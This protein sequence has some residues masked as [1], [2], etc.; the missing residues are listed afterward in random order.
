MATLAASAAPAAPGFSTSLSAPTVASK[1]IANSWIVRFDKDATGKQFRNTRD[2]SKKRGAK[3]RYQYSRVFQGFAATM[4]DAEVAKLRQNA[5]VLSV[6]PDYEVHASGTQS[7]APSWGL[8]RIDQRALPLSGGYTYS[9]TGSG[10]TAY[11][12]D[13][14]IRASHNDFGG[15]VKAGYDVFTGGTATTD[16]NGHGTHVAGTIGGTTYGVAKQVAL[17]PVRVLDCNGGGSTSGVIA[18][19]DWVTSHHQSAGGPAVANMSLGGSASQAL[20]T[21]VNSAITAGVSFAVAAG[22][23][24]GNAC[25]YS[26][27]RVPAAVTVGASTTSDT[28]ASFSNGGS[29]VDIFAPGQSI[30]SDYGSGDTATA[31]ISG[32]S[33]A[34]PHVAGVIA[35]YLQDHSTATPAAIRAALV[36]NAG[37]ALTGLGV[38]S[39]DKLLYSVL[40]GG[41][42]PPPPPPPGDTN[43]A[44]VATAPAAVLAPRGNRLGTSSV[45][46]SVSWVPAAD[47]DGDAIT[48]YTLQ[49]SSNAGS[50]W[51]TISLP[52]AAATSVTVNV[53]TSSSVFR[54]RATDARG[55]SG[56]WV[57]GPAF[58]ATIAQQG[59]ATLSPSSSWTTVS[60]SDA[61]GGS[62]KQ[63]KSSAASA[64]YKFTGSQVAWIGTYSPNRGR[65]EVF[66]DG[67][68][69]GI[70]DLYAANVSTRQIFFAKKVASGTHT[71]V[72]KVLGTRSSQSTST[73]VDVDAFVTVK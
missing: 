23:N 40:G 22:N 69:Q 35:T 25:N 30:V 39:P 27:S 57:T 50:S 31:S 59:A 12:I 73:Y 43:T 10:V 44:P 36:D 54:L 37:D 16:C 5:H 21:A 33:M 49:Y 72:I 55:A 68:S 6:E 20:D 7:P 9:A 65:A 3:V 61:S 38:G 48:S 42:T 15:R 1:Q 66:L 46:M 14:G 52:S 18:G 64:T 63:A 13:T 71:L 11:V 2:A 62:L 47:A 45:P 17:I 56:A 29:C 28:P 60:Y 24:T 58:T 41:T 26:P 19:V 32:T 51:T 67:V 8:D 34:S 4:P 53:L 70:V